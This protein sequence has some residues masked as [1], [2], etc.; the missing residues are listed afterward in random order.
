M[1]QKL[2]GTV[3]FTDE[4][5]TAIAE[6]LGAD[7]AQ[8]APGGL[9]HRKRPVPVFPTPL[10]ECSPAAA[11]DGEDRAYGYC[12]WFCASEVPPQGAS[13]SDHGLPWCESLPLATMHGIGMDGIDLELYAALARGYHHGIYRQD[14][15]RGHAGHRH[16]ASFIHFL[17]VDADDHR[18]EWVADSGQTRKFAAGLVHATDVFDQLAASPRLGRRPTHD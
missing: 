1:R 7:V 9:P 16:N 12:A 8:L 3:P 5:I 11:G 14:Q 15:L 2:A 4:E 13:V 17:L 6:L 18:A 10:R